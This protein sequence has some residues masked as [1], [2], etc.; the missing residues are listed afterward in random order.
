MDPELSRVII[1]LG[2]AP[3]TLVSSGICAGTVAA[4]TGLE[5]NKDKATLAAPKEAKACRA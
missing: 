1:I 2:L 3:A 4:V 5:K